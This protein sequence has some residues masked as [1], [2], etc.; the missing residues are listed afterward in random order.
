MASTKGSATVL[1]LVSLLA[2]IQ[3]PHLE[4]GAQEVIP[5]GKPFLRSFCSVWLVVSAISHPFDQ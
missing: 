5:I 2:I 4:C 1:L 3:R